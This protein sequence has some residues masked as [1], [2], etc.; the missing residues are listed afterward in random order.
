LAVH[1]ERVTTR[2][3]EASLAGWIASNDV[4]LFTVVLVMVIAVFLQARVVKGVKRQDTLS[5]EKAAVNAALD[6]TEVDLADAR[7]LLEKTN[8]TLRLTQEERDALQA[9]LVEKLASLAELNARLEALLAE[10]GALETERASL[11]SA[12][13]TL[14]REKQELVAEGGEL[15]ASNRSLS[16]RLS[17]LA[18]D[19]ERKVAAL[20]EI[21][22][23]RDRLKQQSEELGTIIAGLKLRLKEM[24]VELVA[25]RDDAEAVRVA[26]AEEDQKLRAQVA[27]ADATAEDYLKQLRSATTLLHSLEGQKQ[28]LETELSDAERAHQATLLAEAE[29]NKQLVGLRGPMRRVAVLFDASGS[30]LQLGAGG[31]DRWA[32]AQNIASTWLAHL[33]VEQCLLIVYSTDVR[34]FPEDGTLADVRGTEG[35]ARR[36]ALL[37]LVRSIK[38]AG[39]TNTLAALQKA[40]EY[41]VDTILLL[42]DGAPS[43]ATTG[44]YDAALARQIYELC[45]SHANI[46]VNTIGL[47]NYFDN[48]MSTFLRTVASITG[49][50]FRGQ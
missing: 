22:T 40:Y 49:G 11:V 37:E 10:K 38:P 43:R 4:T 35:A 31:A 12:R 26:S 29:N 18:A 48:E 41:D 7:A 42:S 45:Q 25:A 36:T 20:E 34:T 44:K 23:Q 1:L 32:E 46:P 28:Q 30:M 24:H 3:S 6:A 13:D 39:N 9:Q 2:S 15:T 21:E 50:G 14:L 5:A 17:A 16:Q 8:G 47:G 33:N 19:L 27:T